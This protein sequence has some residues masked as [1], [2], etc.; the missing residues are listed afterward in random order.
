MQ[1]DRPRNLGDP[2]ESPRRGQRQGQMHKFLCGS[3]G[4]PNASIVAVKRLIPV[5][6]RDVTVDMQLSAIGV[7]IVYLDYY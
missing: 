4:S 6:P 5:E 2:T 3:P 1:T 7:Q